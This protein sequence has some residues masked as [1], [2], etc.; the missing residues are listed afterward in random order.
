MNKK[1]FNKTPRVYAL[2]LPSCVKFCK[3]IFYQ[4]MSSCTVC[5]LGLSVEN[6]HLLMEMNAKITNLVKKP[7]KD[8]FILNFDFVTIDS[9]KIKL[10]TFVSYHRLKK[11]FISWREISRE[12]NFFCWGEC[13]LAHDYNLY[14]LN[15]F[16]IAFLK[17]F[18]NT[19]IHL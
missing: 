10:T 11:V 1:F 18:S 14:I 13:L 8:S 17:Y 16:C 12:T 15:W 2:V 6:M 9:Q 3:E 5:T 4:L 7:Q 19:W